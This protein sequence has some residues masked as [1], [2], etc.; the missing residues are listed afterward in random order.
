MLTGKVFLVRSRK[1]SGKIP[2]S[3]LYQHMRNTATIAA[4]FYAAGKGEKK[5]DSP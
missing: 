1:Y 5:Q 4:A 2:T 3:S